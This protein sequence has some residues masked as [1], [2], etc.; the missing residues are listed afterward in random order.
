[1]KRAWGPWKGRE[2]PSSL[3]A[4]AT[5]KRADAVALEGCRHW[6]RNATQEPDCNLIY[7]R[8]FRFV[9]LR[10]CC[11]CFLYVSGVVEAVFD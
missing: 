4:N 11:R 10:H 9:F 6:R 5:Q 3:G 7:R 8:Q 1:M 2:I